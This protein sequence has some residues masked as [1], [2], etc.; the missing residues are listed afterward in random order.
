MAKQVLELRSY[1]FIKVCLRSLFV[2]IK[3]GIKKEKN[4]PFR[5]EFMW[6]TRLDFKENLK[7]WWNQDI[8]GTTMFRVH[9]KLKEVKIKL[10]KWNK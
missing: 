6:M 2:E 1:F 7:S 4:A 3:Y 5:F 9:H 8:Q 10:K